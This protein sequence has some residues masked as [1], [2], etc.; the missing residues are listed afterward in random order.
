MQK[1]LAQILVTRVVGRLSL[2]YVDE[3]KGC[4]KSRRLAR[5]RLISNE[6]RL[7]GPLRW[8]V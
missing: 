1:M 3:S 6:K 7:H 5:R 4:A 8:R 2:T